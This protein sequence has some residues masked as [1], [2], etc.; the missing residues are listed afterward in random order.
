MTAAPITLDPDDR[1]ALYLQIAN[2]VRAAV[3]AGAM[4][5]GSR[6]PS[7][8]AL[9]AQLGVARGTVDA[10]YAVLAGEGAV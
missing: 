5:P 8:R 10:A 7:S 1:A 6:L 2:R 4:A 3:V 9:A